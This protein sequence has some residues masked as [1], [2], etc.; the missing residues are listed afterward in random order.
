MRCRIYT[1][2]LALILVALPLT[3]CGKKLT[4]GEKSALKLAALSQKESAAAFQNIKPKLKAKDPANASVC[5]ILL[6][7]YGRSLNGAAV[8]L[9]NLNQAVETGSGLSQRAREILSAE[10][11]TAAS[12]VENF[13]RSLPLFDLSDPALADWSTA[14]LA[15][16][17]AQSDELQKLKALAVK[18]NAPAPAPPAE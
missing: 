7:G 16:A 4:P 9:D 17:K 8:M 13:E 15:V 3:G 2:L 18:D 5:A 12:R 14:H 11:D 6:D 10:A 1:A